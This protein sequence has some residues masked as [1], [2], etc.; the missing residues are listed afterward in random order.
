MSDAVEREGERRDL[1]VAGDLAQIDLE[2]RQ[3][4][5]LAQ[6]VAELAVAPLLRRLHQAYAQPARLGAGRATGAV[7]VRL[8]GAGQLEVHLVRVR[9]RG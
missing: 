2:L 9:V 6:L 4:L 5:R 1:T 7:H 3:T 8:G